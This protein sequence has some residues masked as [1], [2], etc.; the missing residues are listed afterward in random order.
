MEERKK[1][2]QRRRVSRTLVV[3]VVVVVVVLLRWRE[4]DSSFGWCRA[5]E[6]EVEGTALGARRP[7]GEEGRVNGLSVS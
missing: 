5:R 7:S 3:E 6:V 1:R 4:V 2:W